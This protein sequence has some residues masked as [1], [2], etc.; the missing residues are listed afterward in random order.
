V[1]REVT[2]TG[3]QHQEREAKSVA[4]TRA[5]ANPSVERGAEKAATPRAERSPRA[6]RARAAESTRAVLKA[7]PEK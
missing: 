1:A 3:Y 4:S 2:E 5:A 7:N 6:E